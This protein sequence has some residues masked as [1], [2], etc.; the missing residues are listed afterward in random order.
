MEPDLQQR[1]HPDRGYSVPTTSLA[2][3]NSCGTALT[4]LSDKSSGD[5]FTHL[6]RFVRPLRRWLLLGAVVGF[7]LPGVRA[8]DG[9]D[10]LLAVRGHRAV[11]EFPE[12]EHF[13]VGLTGVPDSW[14]FVQATPDVDLSA[15][16]S[17]L[18]LRDSF[19]LVF[20]DPHGNA[21]HR[22][23]GVGARRRLLT[24]IRE[25]ERRERDLRGRIVELDRQ[26]AS[27]VAQRKESAEQEALRKLEGLGVRGYPEVEYAAAR[28]REL[29]ADRW[30]TLVEI[31]AGEG[32]LS[33]PQLQGRLKELLER[34]QG[35]E[36]AARIRQER[37]RLQRGFT[38]ERSAGP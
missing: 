10:P 13:E 22:E 20:L 18:E 16:R 21:L 34:S 15:L 9:V 24:G 27:A 32:L 2:A 5:S 7:S 14:K 17:R 6:A 25:F 11:I 38:V 19:G 35:L 12:L 1:S 23:A 36:V 30:R 31:L 37:Q 33:E 26:R 4:P 8:S 28:L 3:A 29:E